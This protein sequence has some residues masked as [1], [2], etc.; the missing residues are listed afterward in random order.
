MNAAE[1]DFE[2]P[3]DLIAQVPEA[4]RDASRL[5]VF[6]RRTGDVTHRRFAE[7]PEELAEGD[8][9]V[10]NDTKVLPAR[11]RG[12]KPTGGEVE[13]LLLR[14]VEDRGAV[15]VWEALLSGGKSIRPGMEIAIRDDLAAVA[16]A[17]EADTWRIAFRSSNGAATA[18]IEAAGEMPLPPYIK[19]AAGDERA[20]LDRERYQTVFA[21]VPGAVAAPTAGLH[22][23]PELL[24]SLS[25]RGV[26]IAWITLHVG[27]GTFSPLRVTEVEAHRMHEEAFVV[28]E[29]TAAA[30]TR[31]R[32]RGGRIVAVGTT[33][34]RTLETRADDRGGVAPGSGRSS[35]FIYPGFRFR[36]VDALVTNFHLPRSTLLML[37]CAFAG[38]AP[39]LEAYRRAVREGYRFFSYG[40]AML[41]KTA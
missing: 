23:T 31:T 3:G 4:V 12:R 39:V 25:M 6:D 18:A 9:L 36:V 19:R 26:E 30:V 14:R 8:L 28:P 22:F 24:A 1:F 41:V 10:L 21:R 34:A 35:L 37:V 40:D 20:A 29:A 17:R 32:A 15:P 7:L 33:V 16:L 13:L 38:T 5:M 2:L 11:L 27:L